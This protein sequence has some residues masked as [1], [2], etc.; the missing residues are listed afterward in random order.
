MQELEIKAKTAD[1]FREHGVTRAALFGSV[2]RGEAK[3]ESDVDI[4]IEPKLGMGLFGYMRLVRALEE[5]LGRKVDVVTEKSL[6][7]FIKPFIQA[8][9]Q[10][11]YEG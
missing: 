7:K 5:A 2:A 6:N 8:D 1:I 4:L 11:I 3:P 10:T 9:L